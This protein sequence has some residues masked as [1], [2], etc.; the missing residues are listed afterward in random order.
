MLADELAEA[1]APAGREVIRASID[2]FH[3]PRAERYRRGADSPRGYYEDSFDHSALRR[4]LLD[5]LGPGG[6]RRYRRAVFD[7]RT[8]A[9]VDDAIQVA[10]EDALLL[11][12]GVFL[13]RSELRD[14]CDLAIFVT[15]EPE[16]SLRRALERDVELLGSR[17]EVERRYRTRYLPGQ[18]LY[19][20][21]ARPLAA[22]DLIVVNDDPS[23]PELDLRD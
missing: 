21:E 11:V 8:D 18:R 22:A 5:R 14:A 20:E 6:D 12:D 7:F 2:G 10:S 19:F 23:V 1:L 15:V 17:E 16:E 13:L 9:P 4:V 3:R